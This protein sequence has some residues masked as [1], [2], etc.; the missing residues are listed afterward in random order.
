MGPKK[1]LSWVMRCCEELAE[2]L[3]V[4]VRSAPGLYEQCEELWDLL[5]LAG[6]VTKYR[7]ECY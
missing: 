3:D 7:N 2:R 1:A 5:A 4:P 6:L